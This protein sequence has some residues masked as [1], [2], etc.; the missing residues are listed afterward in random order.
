MESSSRQ[1]IQVKVPAGC[2][3]TMAFDMRK[4][5]GWEHLGWDP[6]P[7]LSY[8]KYGLSIEVSAL[9]FR[10]VNYPLVMTNI[11]MV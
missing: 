8:D 6:D 3:E 11:A 5:S 9:N 4:E 2:S 7:D 10:S 1:D